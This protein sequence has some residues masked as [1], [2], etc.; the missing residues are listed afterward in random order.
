MDWRSG[1][2]GLL[3]SAAMAKP[4]QV[5]VALGSWH[6]PVRTREARPDGAMDHAGRPTASGSMLRHN[7]TTAGIRPLMAAPFPDLMFQARTA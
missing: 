1:V 5:P 7:R 6:T 3:I 2:T 4:T